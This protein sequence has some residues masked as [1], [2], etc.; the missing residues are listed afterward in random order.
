[1]CD[2]EIWFITRCKA[3]FQCNSSRNNSVYLKI[4]TLLNK[5]IEYVER[6]TQYKWK[7]FLKL[8]KS[9]QEWERR[10]YLK[11]LKTSKGF[12]NQRSSEPVCSRFP[13]YCEPLKAN[14]YSSFWPP[15]TQLK[16]PYECLS[17]EWMNKNHLPFCLSTYVPT[18]H[19]WVLMC[20]SCIP[21]RF[22][23]L[24]LHFH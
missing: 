9:S 11:A 13:F 7:R 20:T 2:F 23:H 14:T 17:N 10:W 19:P 15:G 6:A 8:K 12:L 22:P 3:L 4:Y 1:M 18:V 21:I 24:R 5:P 16:G